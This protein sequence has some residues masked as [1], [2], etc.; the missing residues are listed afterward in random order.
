[1]QATMK[2]SPNLPSPTERPKL[3]IAL[4]CFAGNIHMHCAHGLANLIASFHESKLQY[5]KDWM[6]NES[7]I[8]RGRNILANHFLESDCT[9]LFFVDADIGFRPKDVALL[10]RG[11]WDVV[12]GAYPRK[13]RNWPAIH[14]AALDGGKPEELEELGA[15]YG[16]NPK[17]EDTHTGRIEVHDKNGGRYVEIMDL[18]TGFMLIRRAA[19]EKFVAHYKDQIAYE[20]DYD[21]GNDMGKTHYR[22]FHADR[23][24]EALSR[25]VMPRYLSED[26]YF[27]RQC[28]AI[29]LKTMLCLDCQ[30]SHSGTDTFRGDVAKLFQIDAP[31]ASTP[32]PQ[33][34]EELNG[35]LPV[36]I[37]E[38]A[39]TP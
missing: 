26:Y 3:F 15:L 34:P 11:E 22:I 28:Q 9:H 25:G 32:P 8:T 16:V 19:L 36:E 13:T 17:L 29:G 23:D 21:G 38:P 20:A 31:A 7:L 33:S 2:R 6:G 14:Q 24:P 12:C 37:V 4:P 27:S 5:Q 18:L 30:L 39:P 10:V 35:E 1:M